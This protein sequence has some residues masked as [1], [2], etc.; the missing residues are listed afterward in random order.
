[1]T[2]DL[3]M[4]FVGFVCIAK[5]YSIGRRCAMKMRNADCLLDAKNGI[6]SCMT[7]HFTEAERMRAEAYKRMGYAG[8]WE[9]AVKMRQLAWDLKAAGV[10]ALHPQWDARQVDDEVRKIFL[11]ATT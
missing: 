2:I 10:K 3:K 11:Y 7:D 5:I 6:F 4:A 9:E 1:M 8:K